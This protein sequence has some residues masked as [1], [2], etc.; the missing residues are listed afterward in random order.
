MHF[1]KLLYRASEITETH[2]NVKIESDMTT[3]TDLSNQ[4]QKKDDIIFKMDIQ[5][6]MLIQDEAA[7]VRYF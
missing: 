7:D 5:I 3:L 6:V 2:R 1:K 4:L